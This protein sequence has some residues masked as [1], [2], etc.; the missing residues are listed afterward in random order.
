M[1]IAKSAIFNNFKKS[2]G[3]MTFV[4]SVDNEII[5]KSKPA[6]SSKPPT[7]KQ[8]AQRLL[9]ATI[10]LFAS[11]MSAILPL[12]FASTG[13][14]RSAYN[15]FMGNALQVASANSLDSLDDILGDAIVTHGDTFAEPITFGNVASSGA[16]DLNPVVNGS[17]DTSLPPGDPALADQMVAL[18]VSP[19][20]KLA[21]TV[22]LVAV[23]G[24][25]W[26]G[27]QVSMY[28]APDNY[29]SLFWRNPV[30][31]IVSDSKI[32]CKYNALTGV[33]VAL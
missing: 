32:I 21:K 30:T 23:R 22:T 5:V 6:P 31:G 11:A 27:E 24:D 16:G 15:S 7:E 33:G 17:F 29:I 10:Q 3:N 13:K 25:S 8:I 1:G 12:L 14:R 2:V 19:S 28:N 18:V 4:Q 20:L 26:E 9:F